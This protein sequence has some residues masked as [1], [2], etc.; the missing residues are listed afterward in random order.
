M[1]VI[2][3]QISLE[4][5]TNALC[6]AMKYDTALP[7]MTIAPIQLVS[8]QFVSLWGHYLTDSVPRSKSDTDK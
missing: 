5:W 6:T 1:I 3:E 4:L 7:H 8:Y 2:N